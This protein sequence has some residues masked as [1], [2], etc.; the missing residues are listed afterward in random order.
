MLWHEKPGLQLCVPVTHSSTSVIQR[1]GIRGGMQGAPSSHPATLPHIPSSHHCNLSNHRDLHPGKAAEPS[2][3]GGSCP[4]SK[5]VI[6]TFPEL[7]HGPKLLHSLSSSM[8]LSF[9]MPQ[10]FSMP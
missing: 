7:L 9:S 4:R 2:H 5:N 8:A 6:T 1:L 3:Q 10:S